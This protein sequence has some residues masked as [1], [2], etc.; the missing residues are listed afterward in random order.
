[1]AAAVV[2]EGEVARVSGEGCGAYKGEKEDQAMEV[3]ATWSSGVLAMAR[4][5]EFG[6]V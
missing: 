1:M 2:E 4:F 5:G 6:D 3:E